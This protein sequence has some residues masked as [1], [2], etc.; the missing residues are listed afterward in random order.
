VEALVKKK[1]GDNYLK[2]QQAGSEL[3]RINHELKRLKMQIA[4]LEERKSKLVA[5]LGR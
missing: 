2:K 1:H 4:A 5:T 3:A